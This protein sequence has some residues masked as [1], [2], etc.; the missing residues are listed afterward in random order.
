MNR[1]ILAMAT[2]RGEPIIL[3]LI[4]KMFRSIILGPRL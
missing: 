3:E 1:L 2:K 4:G